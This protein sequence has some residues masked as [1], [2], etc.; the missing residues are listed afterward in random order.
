MQP[1]VNY[2]CLIF[3]KYQ[4]IFMKK[5][6]KGLI[7]LLLLTSSINVLNAKCTPYST[8][9]AGWSVSNNDCKYT[10]TANKLTDSS[11][12][13]FAWYQGKKL[14]GTGCTYTQTFSTNDSDEYRLVII[15]ICDTTC[16]DTSITKKVVYHCAP[17]CIWKDK[18]PGYSYSNKDCVFTFEADNLKDSCLVY[19]WFKGTDSIG[20]GRVLSYT[21]NSNGYSNI[22]LKIIDT[23]R[24]CDTS[25]CKI[26]QYSCAPKCNWK[27]RKAG[28]GYSTK[29]C[30]Y[31]FEAT[32]LHDSCVTYTWFRGGKVIGTSRLL[33]YTFYG[34]DSTEICLKLNDTCKGCDTSICKTIGYNCPSKCNLPKG[35]SQSNPRCGF[36]EF[37]GYKV[38][39]ENNNI[40]TN[41]CHKYSWSFGDKTYATGKAVSHNY[42]A[43]GTYKVC[44]KVGDSCLKCDTVICKEIVVSCFSKCIWKD[45]KPGF[46]Y[47]N[48]DCVSTFEA[49]NLHDSCIVYK[50]YKDDVYLS[51]GRILTQ[52]FTSNN[53][54]NICL[55]LYDSCNK[56]DTSICKIIQ[57]NCGAKCNWKDTKA[58]WGYSKVGCNYRIEA[59]NLHDSCVT[60]T[61]LS[62]GK[63]IG[64]GR[65]L[66]YEF[67]TH[68]T[69][70]ICLKLRDTCKGCD[71]TICKALIKPCTSGLGY[72]LYNQKEVEVYP[73]PANGS[74]EVEKVIGQSI[75]IKMFD[76]LGTEVNAPIKENLNAIF[77]D[78]KSVS[79]G[80]YLIQLNVNNQLIT[81]KIII[82]H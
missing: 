53:Y 40:V 78:T 55:R 18:K 77:V 14:L 75:T 30:V 49:T 34:K 33:T 42:T 15:N 11:C 61:W 79:N 19:K 10:F 5:I 67:K 68:D 37:D 31:S 22:C 54:S 69:A 64:T 13:Y 2:F 62:G 32:N 21:F 70:E 82:Q 12:F 39:D 66:T 47:G 73:N 81:Q 38:Y 63:E 74:F 71:T 35:W 28:W 3:L 50:W 7:V 36:Y 24:G 80:V 76:L 43:N 4:Y 26:M 46:N 60:Y 1:K 51:S 65:S 6:Y 41:P 9:G 44:M 57:Y 72:G 25:I 45:K 48:K 17:K 58:G 20:N 23:C 27:D 56:C 59:T 29:D 8:R 52:T 16:S